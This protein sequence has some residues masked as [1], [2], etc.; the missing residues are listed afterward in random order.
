MWSAAAPDG[1]PCA[2]KI[3]YGGLEE[4]RTAREVRSLRRVMQLRHP[5]LLEIEHVGEMDGH[6]IIVTPLADRSISERFQECRA[7]GADGIPR[8]ELLGYLAEAAEALDFL[9]KEHSLQHLDVKPEN[10][11]LF[12][13]GVKV[14]DFGPDERPAAAQPLPWWAA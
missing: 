3:T 6:V 4:K 5:R 14:A 9:V 8:E 12:E 13:D 1:T 11:L 10:L 2:V 7:A